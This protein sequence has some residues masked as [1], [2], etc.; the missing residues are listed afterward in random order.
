[1]KTERAKDYPFAKR[2][3]SYDSGIEGR[4]SQRFYNLL[5]GAISLSPGAAVL[6]VGCGTGAL[7][8]KLSDK[9]NIVGHGIDVEENMIAEAKKQ[10]PEMSF[11]IGR[12]DGLPVGDQALD[13][14]IACLAY[15][16]FDNKPGF[17]AEAARVLKPGGILYIADP[18][19]PWV[20]RKPLNGILRIMGM[21]GR[22][23]DSQEI[24]AVFAPHGFAGTGIAADKYA[25]VIK[26]Q[27]TCRAHMKA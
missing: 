26:L 16:H 20:V 24:E 19:L 2:A 3:S 25:Q 23:N 7:L 10:C 13:A 14:V 12:C 22:I 21:V 5:L 11:E 8:K 9:S 27:K 17:A 1:M 18:R 6:D 4:A 15:H